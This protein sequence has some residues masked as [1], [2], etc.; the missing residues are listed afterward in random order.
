MTRS[1]EPEPPGGQPI[2]QAGADGARQ[3]HRRQDRPGAVR[4]DARA[5]QRDEPQNDT[6][7][8][9]LRIS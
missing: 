5:W 4:T 7:H 8:P 9:A 3:I 1:H 6:D 2:H